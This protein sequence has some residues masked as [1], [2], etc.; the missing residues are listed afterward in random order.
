MKGVPHVLLVDKKGK[1]VF[2]GHP[3]GRKDLVAD[4][5]TLLEDKELDGVEA[6]GE[7]K[8]EGDDK[9]SGSASLDDIKAAMAEMTKFRET[10]KELQKDCKESATGMMRNFCVL[11]LD[12]SLNPKTGAWTS[13]YMNHRVLV[14]P[15]EKVDSCKAK[16]EE[17]MGVE[18]ERMGWT[19]KF[20]EQIQAM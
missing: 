10:G 20:N 12:A 13:E 6:P 3:A 17:K 16:I 19:F 14:G 9:E 2:K 1:I 11:T 5:N 8:E 4:F 18:A 15:K 7:K